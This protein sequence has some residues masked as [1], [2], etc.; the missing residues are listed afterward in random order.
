MT[1]RWAR[2][3]DAA[4]GG[5]AVLQRRQGVV[6]VERVVPHV[7]RASRRGHHLRGDAPVTQH[8]VGSREGALNL[9]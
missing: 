8:E 7:D 3:I 4:E 9:V 5:L 2:Q 6:P 1:H